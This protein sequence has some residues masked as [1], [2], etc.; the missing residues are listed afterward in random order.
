MMCLPKVMS[1]IP[2]PSLSALNSSHF[3]S[4]TYNGHVEA[5]HGAA[6]LVRREF[7]FVGNVQIEIAR[8]RFCGLFHMVH[9][10]CDR[11]SSV[12]SRAVS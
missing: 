8:N 6:K 1:D 3:R 5:L 7:I 10:L 2:Y 12:E 11:Q 4:R 9:L